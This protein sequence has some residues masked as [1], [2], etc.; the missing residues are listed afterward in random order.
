MSEEIKKYIPIARLIDALY[1]NQYQ[2]LE[3]KAIDMQKITSIDEAEGVVLDNLGALVGIKRTSADDNVY[4]LYIKAKAIINASNGQLNELLD[5]LEL[6]SDNTS[7]II[8]CPMAL[9]LYADIT[10]D[11]AKIVYNMFKG[12]VVAGVKIMTIQ[13]V[14]DGCFGFDGAEDSATFGSKEDPNVGG[15]FSHIIYKG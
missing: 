9:D 5:A 3:N 15:V 14:S 4:R 6:I 13:P 10:E 11:E 1:S 12:A 7:F 8:I 2:D